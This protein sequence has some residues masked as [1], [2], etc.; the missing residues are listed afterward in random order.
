MSKLEDVRY[1]MTRDTSLRKLS[2]AIKEKKVDE[3]LVPFLQRFNKKENIFT[4][5]SCA[6]RIILLAS[7]KEE[8]KLPKLFM[9]KWHRT[10]KLKE[11]LDVLKKESKFPEIWLKQE[12]FIFHFVCKDLD[13]AKRVLKLKT[14]LGIK[15]GGIFTIKDGRYIIELLGTNNMSLP[16]KFE[17]DIFLTNNQLENIIK[18]ANQKLTKNYKILKEVMKTFEKEL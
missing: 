1:K 3:M 2:T 12:P 11:I 18:K 7:D 13:N 4:S 6:G 10:V 9:G 15:R 16:V 17:N 5:S 8:H 14:K